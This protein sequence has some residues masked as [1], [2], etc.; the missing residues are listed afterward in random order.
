MG[1]YLIP[2]G[3]S[4]EERHRRANVFRLTIGPHGSNFDDVVKALKP[5]LLRLEKGVEMMIDGEHTIV[6]AFAMAYT[7][8]FPQQAKNSATRCQ[9]AKYSCRYCLID[10]ENRNDLDFDIVQ[11]GR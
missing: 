6:H 10:E 8:D 4:F 3:L 2:A 11:Y 9:K 7:A 5:F 1:W